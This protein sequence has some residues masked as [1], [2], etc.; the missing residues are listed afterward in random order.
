MTKKSITNLLKKNTMH[1]TSSLTATGTCVRQKT[2]RINT[3]C[4]QIL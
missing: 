3:I 1:Q 2:Y 4:A